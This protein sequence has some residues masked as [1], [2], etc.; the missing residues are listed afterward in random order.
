MGF[1]FEIEKRK[2]IEQLTENGVSETD[3]EIIADCFATADLYVLL[4]EERQRHRI[5]GDNQQHHSLL[6]G[7]DVKNRHGYA[8]TMP[9]FFV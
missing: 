5:L 9:L 2:A 3:A 4:E 8:W 6:L 1:D 7:S